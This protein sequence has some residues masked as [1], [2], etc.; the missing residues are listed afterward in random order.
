MKQHSTKRGLEI[1][2]HFIAMNDELMELFMEKPVLE[3][4]TVPSHS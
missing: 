3:F 4:R 1:S 2:E